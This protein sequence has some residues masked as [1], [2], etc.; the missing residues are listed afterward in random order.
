MDPITLIVTALAA[1]A[2]SGALAA[3]T[4]EAKDGVKAAL[5]RLRALVSRRTAGNPVAQT[6]LTRYEASPEVWRGPLPGRPGR[7]REHAGQP[8]LS[9][10]LGAPPGR[11]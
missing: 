10:P 2:S 1:G 8:L 5:T 4:D 3:L 7:R 11:S 9:P 6:A